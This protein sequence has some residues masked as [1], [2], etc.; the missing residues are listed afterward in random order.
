MKILKFTDQVKA[1]IPGCKINAAPY[2]H[3]AIIKDPSAPMYKSYWYMIYIWDSREVLESGSVNAKIEG[4]KANDNY[5]AKFRGINGNA[6]KAI[7]RAFE[8]STRKK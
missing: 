3:I 8:N 2:L 4:S 7:Q 5:S 1:Q 6:A